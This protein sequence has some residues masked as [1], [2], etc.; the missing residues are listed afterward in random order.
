MPATRLRTS[1]IIERV[2]E[3]RDAKTAATK[4]V[5]RYFASD[6][7]GFSGLGIAGPV[8]GMQSDGEQV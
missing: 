5:A 6:S 4:S 3:G 7:F 2:L 8:L 1:I